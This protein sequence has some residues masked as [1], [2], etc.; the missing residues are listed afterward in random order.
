MDC[1]LGDS[2]AE[3]AA[4]GLWTDISVRLLRLPTL[5]EI[6][7]E[8]LG[9]EIIPRSVLLARFEKVS[10]LAYLWIKDK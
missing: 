4:V 8:N 3:L 5:E 7:R 10:F 9:G 2:R 6:C 1:F